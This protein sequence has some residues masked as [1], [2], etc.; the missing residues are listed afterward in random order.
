MY[1]IGLSRRQVAQTT[2]FAKLAMDVMGAD[3]FETH[4]NN[5]SDLDRVK[6]HLKSIGASFVAL[7]HRKG[8][9]DAELGEKRKRKDSSSGATISGGNGDA[10]IVDSMDS[11]GEVTSTRVEDHGKSDCNQD[12]FK[13]AADTRN[14]VGASNDQDVLVALVWTTLEGKRFFQAFPEQVS[15]DGTHKTNDEGW[16]LVTLSV[17]DMNGNQEVTIRCWAPNNR[18]WL[19]RWLFQTAIPSMMGREACGRVRLVITDGD[20]QECEQ[21]DA[22]INMVFKGAKR[23]RCGWHIVDRG[24]IRKVGSFRGRDDTK[25]KEIDALVNVIKGWLYSHMKEVETVK[26]YKL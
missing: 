26:E 11:S 12:L 18:A 23:R 3:N 16:E 20:S 10:L 15:V 1:G 17:Q 24:W 2:Q 14:V 4:H 13:Y 19:F 21:M 9:C 8:D 25:R 6:V 22:A 5:M 7:Y